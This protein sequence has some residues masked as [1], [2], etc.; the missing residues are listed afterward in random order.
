[1]KKNLMVLVIG[2]LMMTI[3]MACGF[4]LGETGLSDE[5]KLQTAVAATV[6]AMQPQPVTPTQEVA[7]TVTVA[8]AA[9]PTATQPLPPTATPLPCNAAAY[10][11]ETVPD[12]SDIVVGTE[13]DKSWRLMNVGTCTW[14]SSYELYFADG[15]K[16]GGPSDV[17]L[18]QNVKPGEQ[19]D[20]SVS[21]KAPATADTYKGFWKVRDDQGKTFV[22]NLWVEIDAKAKSLINPD[23]L[24][25]PEI[26][27]FILKPTPIFEMPIFEIPSP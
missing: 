19:V 13:F 5:E 1:M 22:N 6:A 9:Q 11:G 23:L 3:V 16:M 17:N 21:L 15:D 2:I 10:I 12:G 7:P 14:N 24:I 25:N 18:T 27:K 26:F 20:I 8:P 4:S